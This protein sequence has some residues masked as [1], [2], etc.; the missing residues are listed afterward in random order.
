MNLANAHLCCFLLP[1]T[2]HSLS[3]GHSPRACECCSLSLLLAEFPQRLTHCLGP[4][5][6]KLNRRVSAARSSHHIR[7][8]KSTTHVCARTSHPDGSK[9]S[10]KRGTICVECKES[11]RSGPVATFWEKKQTTLQRK[12][13]FERAVL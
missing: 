13:C 11:L 9:I 7:E 3:T 5:P 8:L 10:Q 6:L 2:S 4:F 12:G 1:A